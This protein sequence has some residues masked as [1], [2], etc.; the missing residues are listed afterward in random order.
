[1]VKLVPP[2][3]LALQ[4]AGWSDIV[5]RNSFRHKARVNPSFIRQP[6][7]GAAIVVPDPQTAIDD[8]VPQASRD[9]DKTQTIPD[10]KNHALLYRA[11]GTQLTLSNL[12]QG[13]TAFLLCGGP[14]LNSFDLSQLERRGVLTMA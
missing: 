8:S 3:N 1:L 2:F 13:R 9:Q 10:V 5:E 12:Y 11:D 14:S 4:A 6:A 7:N